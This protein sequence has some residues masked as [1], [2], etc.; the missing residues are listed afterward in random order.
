VTSRPQFTRAPKGMVTG[1]LYQF[2]TTQP[3]TSAIL[4]APSAVTHSNDMN[5]RVVKVDYVDGQ[6]SVPKIPVPGYYM[7]FGMNA[8]GV[9]TQATWVQLGKDIPAAPVVV[10]PDPTPTPTPTPT[11]KPPIQNPPSTNPPLGPGKVFTPPLT[12]PEA[13]KPPKTYSAWDLRREPLANDCGNLNFRRYQYMTLRTKKGVN[14]FNVK[15]GKRATCKGALLL[16][17]DKRLKGY[18]SGK[19]KARGYICSASRTRN[20]SISKSKKIHRVTCRK[21]GYLVRWQLKP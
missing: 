5:Q 1:K 21:R 16:I 4:M 3:I 12:N 19:R 17:M 18:K 13:P 2:G 10:P 6:L 7:L 14:A 15:I 20:R 9:P 8:A 11:P